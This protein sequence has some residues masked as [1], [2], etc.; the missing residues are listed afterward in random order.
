MNSRFFL[1]VFSIFITLHHSVSQQLIAVK[2]LNNGW[3]IIENKG[4]LS[5]ENGLQLDHIKYFGKDNGMHIYFLQSAVYFVFSKQK[6]LTDKASNNEAPLNSGAVDMAFERM[7][8]HFSECNPLVQIF[9]EN[10]KAEY[11]NY[12]K[13][14]T[15]EQNLSNIQMFDR[16]IY[17]NLYEGIDLICMVRENGLKYEFVVHP[18]ANPDHINIK[19]KGTLPKRLENGGI[20]YSGSMGVINESAPETFTS[21][22]ITIPS[23]FQIHREN[24][25]KFQLGNY[26][27]AETIT[28][29]PKLNWGTYYGNTDSDYASGITHDSQGNLYLIGST[30]STSGMATSGAFQTS[31]AG[32]EDFFIAKFSKSGNRIW[33]TY[34]G[35]GNEEY[36]HGISID[37]A[38]NVY[39]TGYSASSGL[40][41]SGA[42]QT[43]LAGADDGVIAKFNK[44][45]NRIWSTYF[46]GSGRENSYA[47]VVDL[48][49][50]VF[51][52][53]WTSSNSGI[54]SSGSFQ[55]SYNGANDA[56]IAKF[57]K[58]G[59][60]YWSTYYGGS[61]Q[62][63]GNGLAL[64]DSGRI[65]VTGFTES[66]S[67]MSSS[68]AF[69]TTLSG[70]RDAFLACFSKSGARI[71]STYVG[72]T[73]N[74]SA[75]TVSTD[76]TGGVTISGNT[77]S[78]GSMATS[79]THQT[80]L[81]GGTDVFLTR[82]NSN[83]K[84]LWSTY[85]GGSSNDCALSSVC[86]NFGNTYLTGYTFSSSGIAT[87]GSHQSAFGGGSREDAFAAQFDSS[88]K[89]IKS[90]YFG[91]SNYDDGTGIIK[92]GSEI[93]I[94]GGT[95]SSAG[96]SSSGS[97]QKSYAGGQD[98]YIASFK[99]CNPSDT[100][101][102]R[103]ACDSFVLNGTV[104]RNSGTFTQ[105]KTNSVQCD[106]IITLKLKILK[107][108]STVIKSACDSFVL[109]NKA[110]YETGTY[111][112]KLKNKAGCDSTIT[113]K[114][115]VKKSSDTVLTAIAC[116]SYTLNSVVYNTGGTYTQIR[117]NF[118]GCDSLITLI[119]TI[120]QGNDTVLNVS[121][122]D[123]YYFN[124]TSYSTGG[125]YTH[126]LTGNNGCDSTLVLHLTLNKSTA[127]S[128]TGFACDSFVLNNNSYKTSGSYVQMLLNNKGCDSILT[129]NLK[130]MKSS[131]SDISHAGCGSFTFNGTTY[132]S[133]GVYRQLQKN[134][135]G[136]D[137]IIT[138]NLNIYK[139]A[140]AGFKTQVNQNKVAFTP[141]ISDA[142][143][144]EWD[145][146]NAVKSTLK[147]PVYTYLN[148]GSYKVSLRVVTH[149]N[150]EAQH[151]TTLFIS[152]IGTV[153]DKD[154]STFRIYPNP[155]SGFVFIE[156]VSNQVLVSLLDATG[157]IL[158]QMFH[159]PGA[160][161]PVF[162]LKPGLYIIRINDGFR[163]VH[164]KLLVR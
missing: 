97:Y 54:A 33:S 142:K 49:G 78:T 44:N 87:S 133:G 94:T 29:D 36:G 144:Y 32:Y 111:T 109:N 15:T 145:F 156:G 74:E 132:D 99:F 155:A 141:V 163:S 117:P 96:I 91:G 56:F 83:G 103:E 45:G 123:Q 84:R 30:A 73:G 24:Q 79:G 53:G 59:K 86:D 89:R 12:Y 130:V 34:F 104:Y 102:L 151:D 63:W 153:S 3:S 108:Q 2:P 124:G 113:L 35:G 146:G 88:G 69:Q 18:G 119:L 67:G 129:L 159:D 22:G 46:G 57:D 137:S 7:E 65:Y 128:I 138:L 20:R 95:T 11:L 17:K 72:G 81:A 131:K 90:T 82:F 122:C 50:D 37:T 154:R 148:Q 152:A 121:A 120:N 71:W 23:G 6:F 19:W 27:H 107:S 10:P 116:G 68:N 64:G 92:S 143:T 47:I 158:E 31:M 1:I 16:L 4:Q 93:I 100:L 39:I 160:V 52:S 43:T 110:Y 136:C 105:Y 60:N 162:N 164:E 21:N 150:C 85:Y 9:P 61:G 157:N 5:D 125:N 58:N 115:V 55:S 135:A 8:M 25:I 134:T 70:T 139:E 66:N 112:Q 38:S 40:A 28:I 42:Y 126:T 161:I 14:N 41:T 140:N 80:A 76:V 101:L 149:E 127:S 98:A 51:I 118:R 147:S 26:N 75:E 114:L 106:S 48:K 13:S 62:D 77:N